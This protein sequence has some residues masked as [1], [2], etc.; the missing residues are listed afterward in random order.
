MS[1]HYKTAQACLSPLQDRLT[2]MVKRVLV[3]L[4]LLLVGACDSPPTAPTVLTMPRSTEVPPPPRVTGRVID[5]RGMPIAG[6][7]IS[8]NPQGVG[9]ITDA[10]GFY[11]LSGPISPFGFVL[12]ATRDGYEPNYQV[13]PF[14]AEAVRNFRLR[15]VV[16]ITAG[17]GVTVAVDSDDTLYGAAEQY[18]AR[19]VRVAVQGTGTLVVEGSSSTGHAVLLSDRVFEYS[20]CCPTRLDIAVTAGQEVTVHVLT[21]FLE[22][23]AEFSVTT[24]L[25]PR[26]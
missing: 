15:G 4:S 20:P 19:T 13:V 14:A 10:A 26:S 24:R 11:E 7:A 16:R 1:S 3:V 2:A 8:F 6:A 18:R 23:P 25:E 17:E 5:E 21:Y 22:V 12:Y 9:I